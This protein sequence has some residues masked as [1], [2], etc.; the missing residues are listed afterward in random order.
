MSFFK[1]LT[2][3]FEELKSSFSDEPKKEQAPTQHAPPQQGQH[4]QQRCCEVCCCPVPQCLSLLI[5]VP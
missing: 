1:K 2:K 3:E 4:E 5:A